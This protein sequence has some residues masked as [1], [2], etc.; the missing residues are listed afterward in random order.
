MSFW[1]AENLRRVTGGTWLSL[2]E[3]EATGLSTDTRTLAPGQVFLALRGERLDGHTMLGD[4][5]LAGSPL[6]IIDRPASAGAVPVGMGVLVV[7]DTG[8]ALLKLGAAYRLTLEKTRVVAVAGSNGKTTTVRL[9]DAVLGSGLRGSASQKSFNNHIGVPLTVLAAKPSD[10]Y[11]VC[12]IGTNSPGEV[13]QLAAVVRPDLAVITSVGREHLEKL[14]SL[15]GVAREE[16]SV[17][18]FVREGGAGIVSADSAELVEAVSGSAG[19]RGVPGRSGG[20]AQRQGGRRP[21]TVIYFGEGA[22]ADVRVASTEQSFDGVRFTL[23]DRAA[24]A[25]PLLGRHNAV[26]AAGA[27]AVGRRMG[28]SDGQIALGLGRVRGAEMRLERTEIAGV[29]V[30]NDAYN[31]NPDSMAAALRTFEEIGDRIGGGLRRVVVL[32][33]M[34]ELGEHAEASHR[35]VGERLAAV[36]GLD[37]AVLVGTWMRHAARVLEAQA[38]GARIVRVDELDDGRAAEVAGLLTSG[39]LVLLKGSRRM[40]LERVAAALREGTARKAAQAPAA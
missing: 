12:E 16:A 24:F 2:P 17:L 23:N 1:T 15:R 29:R 7:Q 32:G 22:R 18:E 28:L 13:A 14:S 3:R 35:E 5:A 10:Q 30:I 39:D 31:A 4:A 26:N 11:L 25:I 34:L 36:P 37:L 38:G 6:A 33:D 20:V 40:R 27:V 9:I 21:L 8:R 19:A